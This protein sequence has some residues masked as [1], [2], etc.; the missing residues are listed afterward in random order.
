MDLFDSLREDAG[1]L[2]ATLVIQGIDPY[3]P[4]KLT[5]AAAAHLG[6]TLSWVEPDDPTLKGARAVHDEQLGLLICAVEPDAPKRALMLAH[7]IGHVRLHKVSSLCSED[8][9]D[10]SRSSEAAP[11]GL[12]RVEDYGAHERRELQANVYGRE[13]LLP[14]TLAR[15]LH[16]DE[17]LG[18]S[19]IAQKL[20][21]S[22]DLVRQQILDALLLPQLPEPEI[23]H[24]APTQQDESQDRAAAYRGSAFLLQAGPGAGKTR[25]LVKRLQGLLS[26]NVDPASIL[27][28]TFSN[29]AAGELAERITEIAPAVAP[30]I[31]IGTFHAFGLDL[32]RRYHDKLDLPADPM[33][34]DRSDAIEVLEEILPTLPLQHYRN[35]WDPALVLRDIVAAIS[36]AK[37]ELA[38][39]ARYRV[40][41]EAMLA[42]AADGD[43]RKVA[44]KALEVAQVYELYERA[45]RERRAVDFGDLIMRPALLLERDEV[46]RE[47]VRLRHRHV[48][49]DEYQDVNLASARLLKGVAG[50][51][52]R[53]WA[54]GD[55]RQSIYRFRGASSSNLTRFLSEYPDAQTQALEINYRSSGEV[56]DLVEGFA[57]DMNAS[58]GLL[59]LHMMAASG[60]SGHR[61]S[62]RRFLYQ[63]NEISGIAASIRELERSGVP[64]REQAVLCRT[65]ARLNDIAEGLE[66][67]DIA[68]LHLGSLFER[69]EVRDCLA[70]LSLAIDPFGTGLVRAATL[71]RYRM[72]LEDVQTITGAAAELPGFGAIGKFAAI[73]AQVSSEGAAS[74]QRLTSDLQGL[75]A[76]DSAWEFLTT[77]FLDRTWHLAEL[78]AD[79]SVRG[80]MRGVA[81]WQFLNFVRTPG[82]PVQGPPIR[83]TLDRVRQLLLLAEERDLRQVPSSALRMD[84]VRLMTIHGSKGLE[85]A[86]VHIPGMVATSIPASLQGQ[87]CPAPAGLITG[88]EGLGE[89]AAKRTHAREEECLFFVAASRAESH[90]RLTLY[91]KQTSGS[92]RGPSTY[93]P[94]IGPFVQDEGDGPEIAGPSNSSTRHP[95]RIDWPDDW[96]PSDGD[97]QLYQGCARRFFYTRVL[98]L[99]TARKPTAFSRT[100]DCL[101]DIIEWLATTRVTAEPDLA[102]T[103]AEFERIWTARGPI[104]HAYALDYRRLA[105]RLVGSLVRCGAGRRFEAS[106]PLALDLPNGRVLVHPDEIAQLPDGAKVLRRVRTGRKRSDEYDRIEYTLYTLVGRAQFGSGCRFEAVHLTD[107]EGTDDIS[108]TE[109]KIAARREVANTLLADL[110]AGHFPPSPDAVRCPRC[111]H[112]FICDATPPGPLKAAPH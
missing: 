71:A 58:T 3:E 86:A 35:L 12:E 97:I 107:A 30:K 72:S 82:P 54:V 87:R 64:L 53:L 42:T 94:R 47:L 2:H 78:A 52:K 38:D 13:L 99:G 88:P 29:R 17:R 51:G 32:V 28:L 7:E 9:I 56:L 39:P 85:F 80:R 103:L 106:E 31:W 43:A 61:P 26:E 22:K 14:R 111:P 100:H 105:L 101:Y 63:E 75:S 41:S 15:T 83:R 55:A 109:K 37:D 73:S 67:R 34:F 59:P 96:H 98:K 57:R 4:E 21:L 81:L 50:D 48:L 102:A 23:T 18:A 44:E 84:A 77:L 89:D 16:L 20:R 69:S 24:R 112:F 10:L 91:T 76:G 79:T 66:A 92:N 93:L 49:V 65:N 6:L 46:L 5:L 95:L 36:R 1:R 8:D 11:V 68:V 110:R 108:I 19:D 62:I 45:L 25:T 33:L 40:L 60:R 104:E 90:L 27:V 70:L 74:F